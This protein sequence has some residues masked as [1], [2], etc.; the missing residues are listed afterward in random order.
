MAYN[1][2][3]ANHQKPPKERYEEDTVGKTETFLTRNVKLIT[4]LTCLVLF[5]AFFG[6]WSIIRIVQWVE[7]TN[8]Q[9]EK[10]ATMMDEQE[11]ETIVREGERLSWASF[12]GYYYETVWETGMC[13]R[14][15]DVL[16]DK[17]HL[18][19]SA[20]SSPA[21]LDSVLLI[22]HADYAEV[23]ILLEDALGFIGKANGQKK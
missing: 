21:P 20:E 4:F 9:A 17:Y 6:P 15:Y 14:Q 12:D 23:D 16:G 5:L 19:V 3:Y 1:G 18:L 22:R 2:Y 8:L 13:I 10:E 11:L 7:A